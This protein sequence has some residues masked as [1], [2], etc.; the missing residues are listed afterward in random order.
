MLAE[1]DKL[2]ILPDDLG[3]AFGEVKG[4]GGLVSAKVVYVEDKLFREV[5][6]FT[7]N[8]PAYAGVNL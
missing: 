3:G 5:F 7:P 2:V 1:A 8:D 6:W 4:E